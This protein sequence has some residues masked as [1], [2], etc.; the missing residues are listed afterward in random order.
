MLVKICPKMLQDAPRAARILPKA[1]EWAD[2][3]VA[4]HRCRLWTATNQP[5]DA[6]VNAEMV[7]VTATTCHAATK[8]HAFDGSRP[9]LNGHVQPTNAVVIAASALTLPIK[10][11][12]ARV[13]G[14]LCHV[15]SLIAIVA[16]ESS[17]KWPQNCLGSDAR[18]GLKRR[19]QVA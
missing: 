4:G 13:E 5:S 19:I 17:I 14:W 1:Q 2:G 9:P 10:G 7:W 6:R 18:T 11:W 15:W 16:P 8:K 12:K 3:F